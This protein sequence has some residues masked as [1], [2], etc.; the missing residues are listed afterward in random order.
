MP[1][2]ITRKEFEDWLVD[3]CPVYRKERRRDTYYYVP[4]SNEVEV[5]L[6]T[7]L[8]ENSNQQP[9]GNLELR[10][11]FHG[12]RNRRPLRTD[13]AGLGGSVSREADWRVLWSD[14]LEDL[15]VE[16]RKNRDVLD[17]RAGVSIQDYVAEWRAR[18]ESVKGW[19]RFDILAD[20]MV[21]L[22]DHRFLTPKQEAAVMDFVRQQKNPKKA[23][24]APK[25]P[26]YRKPD[27]IRAV[28]DLRRVSAND[29]WVQ[30][31]CD[32]LDTRLEDGTPLTGRQL[33]CLFKNLRE[34]NFPVP[35]PI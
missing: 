9:R 23:K 12:R 20:L 22:G 4:V 16:Y 19:Q 3:Y 26:K 17:Q 5:R 6:E 34:K 30:G 31:F 25:K 8:C 24:K 14:V 13:T 15:F 35:T 1:T 11:S 2:R 10:L 33:D 7:S 27:L 28:T 18:I 29:Q 32:S 21:S